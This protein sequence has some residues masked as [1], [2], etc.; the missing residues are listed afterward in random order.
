[1][2]WKNSHRI[3]HL[4]NQRGEGVEELWPGGMEGLE[5]A[6][7]AA[8]QELPNDWMAKSDAEMAAAAEEEDNVR[9][10]LEAIVMFNRINK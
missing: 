6:T 7:T 5:G 4:R 3:F 9:A 2:I 1:M 10:G 8:L